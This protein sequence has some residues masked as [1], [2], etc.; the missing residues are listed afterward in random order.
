[1]ILTYTYR[2]KLSKEQEQ[3]IVS[4]MGV[5]RLVWNM[6]LE[7]KQDAYRKGIKISFFDIERQLKEI[8]QDF[9][10]VSDVP[11]D[12][13]AKSVQGVSLAFNRFFNKG[14][15]P[16]YKSKGG[17]NS[18]YLKQDKRWKPIR[19]ISSSIQTIG[20]VAKQAD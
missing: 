3:R 11:S 17:V 10:W 1:M 7:I 6:T 16:K 18:V 19:Q 15:F 9:D 14:G 13:L 20:M 8:R 5:C 2:L 12:T 4:W